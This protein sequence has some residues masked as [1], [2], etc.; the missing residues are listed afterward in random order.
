VYYFLV[1]LILACLVASGLAIYLGA[2]REGTGTGALRAD[3]STLPV[4]LSVAVAT[5]ICYILR[6][7]TINVA[8][9]GRGPTPFYSALLKKGDNGIRRT[10]LVEKAVTAV[11]EDRVYR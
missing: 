1:L 4:V 3:C 8:H 2:G 6:H 5:A 7:G 11:Y 10:A 9:R